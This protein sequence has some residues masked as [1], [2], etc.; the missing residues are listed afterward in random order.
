MLKPFKPLFADP[1]VFEA[2]E[3]NID[4][5]GLNKTNQQLYLGLKTFC[6]M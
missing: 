5:V 2:M 3:K 6:L 1:I 4:P